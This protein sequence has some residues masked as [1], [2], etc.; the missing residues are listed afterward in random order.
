MC[1]DPH[2]WSNRRSKRPLRELRGRNCKRAGSSGSRLMQ[3]RDLVAA[4]RLLCGLVAHRFCVGQSA[5]ASAVGAVPRN[6]CTLQLQ[7][8][9]HGDAHENARTQRPIHE[10]TAPLGE[11][12]QPHPQKEADLLHWQCPQMAG[13][14]GTMSGSKQIFLKH[15]DNSISLPLNFF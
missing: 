9:R 10:W 3:P 15:M 4:V 14:D 2:S 6:S 1:A 12:T 11:D 7:T 13:C 8:I 5:A